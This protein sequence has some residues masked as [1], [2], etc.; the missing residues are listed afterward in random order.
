MS[1]A[2]TDIAVEQAHEQSAGGTETPRHRALPGSSLDEILAASDKPLVAVDLDDVLS[3]TN[4]SVLQWHN[5]AYGTNLDPSSIYYYYY[6]KNPGWGTP[7]ETFRKVEE[8]YAT[9]SLEKAL[10]IPGALEGLAKLKELGYR[11]VIVTARQRRE[12]HRSA[13]WVETHY[14]NI[15]DD[16]ICTGQSQETLG[17]ANQFVTKLSKA[18][19]CAKLGAKF[20]VD[21]SL[22]NSLKCATHSTPTPVLLFGKN[23]W[24][25]RL[26]KY[27]NIKEELSFE[28]R[29]AKEGGREFWKDENVVIPQDIPLTRVDDWAGVLR[30]VEEQ[31]SLGKFKL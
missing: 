30:W 25:Q 15:F 27:S 19:I 8:Y 14:P 11:L 29:L 3:Q 5:T 2:Q 7:E 10:P 22:E 1:A 12:L 4:S 18:D 21:D 23:E 24:N 31:R 28:Q 6:W 13:R 16:M 17:D 9:D 20:L 26:S